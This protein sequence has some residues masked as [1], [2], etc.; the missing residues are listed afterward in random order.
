MSKES[1]LREMED[2]LDAIK[3]AKESNIK[4][5]F[6]IGAGCSVTAGIPLANDLIREIEKRYPKEF[7]RI[8][9]KDSYGECMTSITALERRNLISKYVEESRVNWANLMLA[10]LLK[11]GVIDCV[12]TTNF[13]N[14]LMKA[15]S[16]VGNFP[17]IYDLA[18]SENFRSELVFKNSIIHLHGQHT[19]FL[20][21]NSRKELD[22]QYKNIEKVFL[23]LNKK[24]MWIILGYSGESDPI[25]EL[26]KINKNSDNRLFWIGY[27]DNDL[28]ENLKDLFSD[29]EK[30]CFFVKKYDADR[31]M[32]ELSRLL[33]SYPPKI[34]DKPFTYLNSI[35]DSI[36]EFKEAPFLLYEK[37]IVQTTKNF[38]NKAIA[39]FEENFE[40]II[41]YYCDLN[42][43]KKIEEIEKNSS[44]DEKDIIQNIK[45]KKINIKEMLESIDKYILELENN[46]N[47]INVEHINYLLTLIRAFRDSDNSIDIL[48][49][50]N[51]ILSKYEDNNELILCNLTVLETIYVKSLENK[52]LEDYEELIKKLD[53]ILEKLFY[54]KDKEVGE[55]NKII[56]KIIIFLISKGNLYMKKSEDLSIEIFNEALKIINDNKDVFN[57]CDYY[58]NIIY[59]KKLTVSLEDNIDL[60][61]EIIGFT[62]KSLDKFEAIKINH[63]NINMLL[64]TLMKF[65]LR[66][67]KDEKTNLIVNMINKCTIENKIIYE[68]PKLLIIFSNIILDIIEVEKCDEFDNVIDK[69]IKNIE[70][71]TCYR[72]EDYENYDL[73]VLC[74]SIAYNLVKIGKNDFANKMISISIGF[75]KDYY[76]VCTKG[77]INLYIKD[78]VEAFESSYELAKKYTEDDDIISAINQAKCLEM[79]EYLI[80]EN[81]NYEDIVSLIDKGIS[82]GEVLN[83]ESLYSKLN[84]LKEFIE[85]N[86]DEYIELIKDEK[87]NLEARQEIASEKL[88]LK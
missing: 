29:K 27:L 61:P 84:V 73:S 88:S 60:L 55:K 62:K 1:Y 21:C 77:L 37:P 34:I 23:E 53:N 24:S 75:K 6:L 65:Q 69:M 56:E 72:G 7:A 79:A 31:F 26:F 63:E 28:P 43:F 19:G 46:N 78:D 22:K 17:A 59:I 83:W 9:N 67:M 87:S 25:V 41:E 39:S 66:L 32:V 3:N 57:E 74:N 48:N 14:I 86:K 35:I 8:E 81:S 54:I 33:G 85:E 40:K 38:V 20:L 51:N 45:N 68:N 70:S 18:A 36:T 30:Y 49:R 71:I 80:G 58:K 44:E 4:I 47:L 11:D 82:F 16:I 42:M 50:L 2:V 15:S 10:Q 76:N 12:L 52:N 64:K 13:D 5:N